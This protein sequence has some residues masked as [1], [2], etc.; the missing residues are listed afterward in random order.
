MRELN[1]A[2]L[3]Q[4]KGGDTQYINPDAIE[5]EVIEYQDGDDTL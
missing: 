1:K 3:L 2:Q 4:V 5:V